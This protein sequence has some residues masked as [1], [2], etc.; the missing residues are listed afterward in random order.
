M[1][2]AIRVMQLRMGAA[3]AIARAL[4]LHGHSSEEVLWAA[5]FALAVLVREGSAPNRPALRAAAAAGILPLLHSCM[6]QYKVNTLAS[7]CHRYVSFWILNHLHSIF[8]IPFPAAM[9][10]EGSL[11]R[12][13]LLQWRGGRH[14]R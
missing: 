11:W 8:S 10:R 14:C 7:M 2:D 5:L 13:F 6:A 3:G 1:H 9:P 12:L 4:Q